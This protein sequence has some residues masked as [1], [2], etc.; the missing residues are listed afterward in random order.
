V[1]AD[2]KVGNLNGF[3]FEAMVRKMPK[4]VE[5]EVE[6]DV[7]GITSTNEGHDHVFFLDFDENGR[8]Q[9]GT[10]SHEQGHRHTIRAGT[11]TDFAETVDV[12][13]HSHR[14]PVQS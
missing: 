10:T 8:V 13:S 3:S 6:A 11:A 2:V 12:K 5:V 4:V 14:L 9:G 1:W 7:L